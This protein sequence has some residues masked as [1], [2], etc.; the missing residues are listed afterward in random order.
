M[1]YMD[2]MTMCTQIKIA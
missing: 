2:Y 1:G